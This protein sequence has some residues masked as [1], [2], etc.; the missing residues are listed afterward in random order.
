[1]PEALPIHRHWECQPVSDGF[2]NS[3]QIA[4]GNLVGGIPEATTVSNYNV[5]KGGA[6][7]SLFP[8]GTFINRHFKANE[9]E[10]YVQDSWRARP[11]LT[12]TF[13]L[14][15]TILQTP[16]EE[17]GQQIAPTIDT[18]A[19]YRQ[20]NAS[21]LH[22]EVYEPLLQFSSE[23]PGKSRSRAL[24]QAKDK[25]RAA[26]G[27]RLCAQRKDFDP[28]GFGLY[29]DHYGEGI[30]NTFDQF[31]SFGL[32]TSVTNP[33]GVYTIENAP[34]FTGVHDVPSNGSA[35]PSVDHLSL[36]RAQ[37]SG[38]RLCDHLGRQ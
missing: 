15:H 29:F 33:A 9:F 24:V 35:Q 30:V 10:W 22:G 25:F 37:R 13:G 3:Y 5:A 8:D 31:G 7:G 19:W 11:N 2:A 23:W 14:R 32:N 21:A 28:G 38:Q 6:T 17:N 12:I 18:D 16:Y 20:R 1:M 4:Y 36:Y 27:H 34:R 26:P